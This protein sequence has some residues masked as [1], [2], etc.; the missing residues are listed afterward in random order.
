[1]IGCGSQISGKADRVFDQK[2]HAQARLVNLAQASNLSIMCLIT[3]VS[4]GT[5]A[6]KLTG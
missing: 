6:V 2:S 4:I 3:F 1:M 5:R